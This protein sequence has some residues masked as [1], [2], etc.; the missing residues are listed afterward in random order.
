MS[1]VFLG[2]CDKRQVLILKQEKVYQE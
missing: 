1:T 2:P